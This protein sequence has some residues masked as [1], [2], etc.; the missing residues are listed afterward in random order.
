MKSEKTV[1]FFVETTD[2]CSEKEAV[3]T[4]TG[5]ASGR[6][7]I[8]E[9]LA[10]GGSGRILTVFDRHVGRKIAMK[11]LLSDLNKKH[12]EVSDP[13]TLAVRNRFLREARV[14]GGL[15]HPSIVPVYEIGTHPD[16]TFYYTMRLVKGT[17]LLKAIKKCASL[18]ERLR[19]LP[20]FHNICNAV[21]YAHSRG[22][23]NRDL[24][25]ANVMIGEF[26]ETVVLDWGLAKIKGTKE[27][28]FVHGGDAGIGKTVVGQAIGTP[29]YMPP[30][31]AEGKIGEI[32]E[33]SDIYSLGAILYQILTG[34]PPFSGRT[35]DEIIGKVLTEKVENA[36]EKDKN[37]PAELAAIAGKALSKDKKER[38]ASVGEMLEDLSA[39]MSGRKVRVYR[40]SVFETLKLLAA[41]HRA[42][43]VSS[44]VI[45]AVILISS[46]LIG[47]LFNREVEARNRAELDKTMANYRTAQALSEKSDRLELEKSYLASRI[48]AAAAMYYNPLNK[49]SPEYSPEFAEGLKNSD[50]MLSKAVSKF[51]IKNFHRGIAFEKDVSVE[52]MI[53]SAA[54]SGDETLVAAGCADGGLT[55]F[56]F[57][58]LEKVYTFSLE[59]GIEKMRFSPDSKKLDILLSNGEILSVNI[60]DKIYETFFGKG[61]DDVPDI[62]AKSFAK[63]YQKENDKITAHAFSPDG[64]TVVSGTEKGKIVIFLAENGDILHVLSFRGS[65]I[66][67]IAFHSEGTYFASASKEGKTVVWDTALLIPLF[68]VDGHAS[69][70]PSVLFAGDSRI[71]TAG[72]DGL[73]RIWQRRGKKGLKILEFK[74]IDVVK[75]VLLKGFEAVALDREGKVYIVS[76]NE[77]FVSEEYTGKS[78][79]SDFDASG[80]GGLIAVAGKDGTLSFL[81]R[82]SGTEKE[83][84]I[85]GEALFSVKISPEKDFVCARDSEKIYLVSAENMETNSIPCRSASR[86][87]LVFSPDGKKIAAVCGSGISFF[88]IPGFTPAGKTEIEGRVPESLEFAGNFSLLAAFDKGILSHIDLSDGSVIDF[89]GRFDRTDKLAVSEDG[90]FAASAA[91]NSSVKLW[92]IRKHELMLSVST[93]KEP[94]CVR[95]VPETGSLGICADGKIRSYPL[96]VPDLR[97]SPAELLRKTEQEAGMRLKDFSLEPLTSDEMPDPD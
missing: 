65:P 31:Q 37:I 73:L 85:A 91:E 51:F 81:E 47:I 23:I 3:K 75:A 76:K 57:P 38:Y 68:A 60:A 66:T 48:Y 34:K 69:S 78:D 24:K 20:H 14:T 74:S 43:F 39:Y 80:D 19:L 53:S 90:L 54:V 56:S 13:Q 33:I 71:L 6:Y 32:D 5:E 26:G 36:S 28:A 10:R 35:T 87:G 79:V 16:G 96:S 97:L 58:E 70:V 29:F 7:E 42:A 8:L 21:A 88:S 63:W 55:L 44:L 49:K 83:S 86:N 67:S 12:S 77:E 41:R 15:E 17:T 1:E 82:S 40:Y 18:E 2:A 93:E 46:V 92:D 64:K 72:E 9:E 25:P 27:A 94:E 45:F 89:S 61:F 59:G 84:K 30:E 62:L 4:V 22:V 52:C 50:G 11:E 95:F